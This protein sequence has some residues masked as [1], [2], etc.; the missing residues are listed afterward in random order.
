MSD[1]IYARFPLLEA[2]K[3]FPAVYVIFD[4][5][6]DFPAFFIIRAW[7]G[8]TPYPEVKCFETLEMARDFVTKKGRYCLGRQKADDPCIVEVWI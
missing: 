7:Y 5:P 4:K 8:M 1:T 2:Q 6:S 3:R